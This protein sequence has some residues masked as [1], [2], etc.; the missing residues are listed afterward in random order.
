MS[1]W[2]HLTGEN[3]STQEEDIITLCLLL[4][5]AGKYARIKI[6]RCSTLCPFYERAFCFERLPKQTHK[7][8][9][10]GSALCPLVLILEQ[11]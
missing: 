5:K 9:I 8:S 1:G 6:A 11:H 3:Y 2:L 7:I 4:L 10:Q